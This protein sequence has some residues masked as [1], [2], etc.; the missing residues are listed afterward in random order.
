MFPFH[1]FNPDLRNSRAI[2]CES[3]GVL[4]LGNTA[5]KYTKKI[6]IDETAPRFE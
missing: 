1:K 2:V 5:F 6:N 3:I 4:K